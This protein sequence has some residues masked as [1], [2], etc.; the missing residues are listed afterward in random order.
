MCHW[1]LLTWFRCVLEGVL[2]CACM[3]MVVMVVSVWSAI[4][5][6]VV[7]VM[8]VD[9]FGSA[10]SAITV[11]LVMVGQFCG[12]PGQWWAWSVWSAITGVLVMV[13]VVS[14]WSAITSVVVMV[15]VVLVD[16]FVSA[17]SVWSVLVGVL[18][19]LVVVVMGSRLLICA[20]GFVLLASCFY[21]SPMPMPRIYAPA[22]VTVVKKCPPGSAILKVWLI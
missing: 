5:S 1:W 10:W 16:Q 4:T 12:G 20:S 7:M 13:M 6:V 21:L 11:V 19:V 3:V 15:M 22:I 2:I 18:V 8:V 9:Q 17:W 14:V